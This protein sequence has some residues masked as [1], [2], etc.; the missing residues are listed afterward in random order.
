MSNI[1][2]GASNP[3]NTFQ[4]Q[5]DTNMKP[6]D[7]SRTGGEGCNRA[8]GHK[9]I[10]QPALFEQERDT[11][12]P[13]TPKKPKQSAKRETRPIRESRSSIEPSSS[14]CRMTTPEDRAPSSSARSPSPETSSSQTTPNTVNDTISQFLELTA[15]LR[16]ARKGSPKPV[17]GKRR[18]FADD[19]DTWEM[20]TPCKRPRIEDRDYSLGYHA[21]QTADWQSISSEETTNL[22]N[23]L[24][25]PECDLLSVA[26][27]HR[28]SLIANQTD[29]LS[30][31]DLSIL[32][33]SW[34]EGECDPLTDTVSPSLSVR[35]Y[36]TAWAVLREYKG[37][38][39]RESTGASEARVRMYHA[40]TKWT[41]ARDEP[42]SLLWLYHTGQGLDVAGR[43]AVAKAMNIGTTNDIAHAVRKWI[44]GAPDAVSQVHTPANGPPKKAEE[45]LEGVNRGRHMVLGLTPR[46]RVGNDRLPGWAQSCFY[47][48]SSDR[49]K[50]SLAQQPKPLRKKKE[51]QILK[52]LFD[53]DG[54]ELASNDKKGRKT[55]ISEGTN[56]YH[57]LPDDQK[58]VLLDGRSEVE[59]LSSSKRG[60]EFIVV[61]RLGFSIEEGKRFVYKQ[62]ACGCLLATKDD[63]IR[64]IKEHHFGLLRRQNKRK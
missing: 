11:G 19:E 35:L 7:A 42:P 34:K 8:S 62:S 47:S 18:G 38:A 48:N 5:S 63:T 43:H 27:L 31:Q 30:T 59:A 50:E 51:A 57:L 36:D 24:V 37:L 23:S 58:M 16:S 9:E 28:R 3:N 55:L 61:C 60:K 2:R 15:S 53:Q 56:A 12:H 26:P 29:D 49:L 33:F 14:S 22:S 45:R 25:D 41:E 6:V 40:W 54:N 44:E 32:P 4:T 21:A 13:A 20:K 10:D 46:E 39:M 1:Q 52:K 17:L 64:H